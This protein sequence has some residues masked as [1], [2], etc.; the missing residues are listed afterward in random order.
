M[1]FKHLFFHYNNYKSDYNF[2]TFDFISS[3][4][5]EKFV[6]FIENEKYIES[7]SDN[8]II[9]FAKSSLKN[10]LSSLKN[11][12]LIWTNEPR[13]DFFNFLRDWYFEFKSNTLN[14]LKIVRGVNCIIHQTCIL[15]GNICL[16]DNVKIGPYTRI[17]GPVIIGDNTRIGSFVEIGEN[18]FQITESGGKFNCDIPH[19]GN[20]R[21]GS[22]CIISSH[23][24]ISKSLFSSSTVIGDKVSVDTFVQVS[25]NVQIGNNSVLGSMVVLCGG[26]TIGSS[27]KISPSV[28][29]NNKADIADNVVVGLGAVV[30]RKLVKE[31]VYF[32]NPATL[33]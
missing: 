11:K 27:V 5:N 18:G 8:A 17:V 29:I 9:I 13:A 4:S 14:E 3:K 26:V 24:N 20:V 10:K 30:I 25:H 19:I 7:C 12:L 1:S 15:E 23:V 33:I 2:I 21:I 31:G 16:G 32:G 22:N 28:V 6:T